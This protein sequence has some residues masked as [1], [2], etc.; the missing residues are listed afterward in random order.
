MKK[1]QSYRIDAETIKQI[2]RI[3]EIERRTKSNVIEIAVE[4]YYQKLKGENKMKY[5]LQQAM[6]LTGAVNEEQFKEAFSGKTKE[7]INQDLIYMFGT[8]GD[9]ME[10]AEEI[11]IL[12]KDIK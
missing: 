2:D 11:A 10:F 4:K 7:E 9:D 12:V 5:N 3:G 1:M 8:E 6:E